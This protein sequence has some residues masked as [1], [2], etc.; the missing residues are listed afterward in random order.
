MG[1]IERGITM[2]IDILRQEFDKLLEERDFNYTDPDVIKKA[3]ELE[4]LLY[5]SAKEKIA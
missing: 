2:S 4:R 5:I 3:L 1:L